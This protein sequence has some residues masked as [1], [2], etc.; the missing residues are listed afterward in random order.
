M[1]YFLTYVRRSF[2]FWLYFYATKSSPS[3]CFSFHSKNSNCRTV[4]D[5]WAEKGHSLTSSFHAALKAQ[6]RMETV[7]L[8]GNWAN[9]ILKS[10][11]V[12]EFVIPIVTDLFIRLGLYCLLA[13]KTYVSSHLRR[14]NCTWSYYTKFLK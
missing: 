8:L 11:V 4:G 12:N 6:L 2:T 10:L 14:R 5:V 13:F 1:D 3:F 9:T 7:F